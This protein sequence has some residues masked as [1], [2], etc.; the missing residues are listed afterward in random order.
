M[1]PTGQTTRS[2]A[3]LYILLYMHIYKYVFG[4]SYTTVV[5]S[6][7]ITIGIVAFVSILTRMLFIWLSQVGIICCCVPILLTTFP[8]NL[9]GTYPQPRY[10]V[11][12]IRPKELCHIVCLKF[13]IIVFLLQMWMLNLHISLRNKSYLFPPLKTF[14]S[15]FIASIC[16]CFIRF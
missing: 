12:W 13:E 2:L 16:R 9:S 4:R 3:R 7:L 11:L 5:V 14:S 8:T 1:V 15:R 10:G 6:I